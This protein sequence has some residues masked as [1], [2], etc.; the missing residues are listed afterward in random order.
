MGTGPQQELLAQIFGT[1]EVSGIRT[2]LNT[3]SPTGLPAIWIID[4]TEEIFFAQQHTEAAQ[5]IPPALDTL[6]AALYAVFYPQDGPPAH[7]P[8]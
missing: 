2:R 1:A 7:R 3:P 6:L 5:P 4:Q 8:S